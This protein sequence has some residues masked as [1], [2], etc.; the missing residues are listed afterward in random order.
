MRKYLTD[1]VRWLEALLASGQPIDYDRLEQ[2]HLVMIGFMQHERLVHF[3]VTMLFALSFIVTLGVFLSTEILPLLIL[4][5]MILALLV[6]YI[7]HYYFLENTV[8]KL[9]FLYDEIRSRHN[10]QKKQSE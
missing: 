1:Y 9:Y 4:L 6:P 5:L 2:R 8:Q 3:L 10:P 7:I